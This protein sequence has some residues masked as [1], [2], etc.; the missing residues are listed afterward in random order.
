MD[1]T[2]CPNILTS[3]TNEDE[4]QEFLR[5]K[6]MQREKDQVWIE[7]HEE[8]RNEQI[9]FDLINDYE[10][11]YDYQYNNGEVVI[12]DLMMENDDDMR[13]LLGISGGSLIIFGLMYC[14]YH[15]MKNKDDHEYIAIK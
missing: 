13:V 11:E 3:I 12:G 4:L 6:E 9:E 15:N 7:I 2:N 1:D 10:D 5:Q 14:L 8:M